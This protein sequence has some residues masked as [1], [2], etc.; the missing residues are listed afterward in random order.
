MLLKHVILGIFFAGLSTVAVAQRQQIT[1]AQDGSGD[2]TT[3]QAALNTVPANN[4]SRVVIRIKKGIY[5]EKLKLDSTQHFVTLIG[6]DKAAT[7]LTYDDYSGKVL[8]DGS[9]LRTSTSGSFYIFGNDFR[10]ENLTFENTAGRRSGVPVGQ[11]VAAFVTGDR[12]VFV[13]CRFLGNQ[14]TLYTGMP[15][16]QEHR[17]D[18]RQY[19]KDCYIEGT[20]DFI[21]GS[22]T[23]V[24]DRCTIFSKTNGPYVTAAA[25]PEGKPYGY[26]FLNCTLTSDAPPASVYLGRPWRNFAKTVF[27]NCQL[28]NHIRPEGWHNWDKPDAEKTAFYAE[29]QSKGPGAVPA[30]RVVWSKQLTAQEASQYKPSNILAGNDQWKPDGKLTKIRF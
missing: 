11:A 18:A 10:A 24:F 1:V 23:A 4:S 12:A 2:F 8:P 13:N 17:T 3:V 29:Y 19:Y 26:V 22:A 5:K 16:N 25:T 7:V 9:K 6:E 20:V 14:D 30:S 15:D 21:F 27:I 28:G